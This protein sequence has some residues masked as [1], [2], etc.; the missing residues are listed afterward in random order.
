M[1]PQ[2][3][4]NRQI[5]I[6]KATGKYPNLEIGEAY[7]KWKTERGEVATM[8]STGDET[9]EASRRVLAKASKKPC[10]AQGCDGEMI[11]ESICAGCV[12]GKHGYKSKWTCEKCL[13]R[14]LSKKDYMEWLRELSLTS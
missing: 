7:R 6:S 4:I 5:E 3:L 8:L 14:E 1:T 10:T 11:L 13:Y 2:E 9:I 12:E